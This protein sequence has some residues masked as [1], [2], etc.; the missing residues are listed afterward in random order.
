M[1]LELWK[2]DLHSWFYKEQKHHELR[3]AVMQYKRKDISFFGE[4]FSREQQADNMCDDI[5][6]LHSWK[7]RIPIEKPDWVDSSGTDCRLH[8]RHI[9]V[10]RKA[11][12]VVLSSRF[13]KE[14]EK[15]IS[16]F[17]K[18]KLANHRKKAAHLLPERHISYCKF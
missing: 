12:H 3:K 18:D 7:N 16:Q 11:G 17:S 13:G 5:L 8:S 14:K 2:E 1:G 6:R 9:S 10:Q 4:S 15:N